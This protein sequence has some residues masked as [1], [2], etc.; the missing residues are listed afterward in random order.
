MLMTWVYSKTQSLLLA[1]LM[2]ASFTGWLL[3]LFPATSLTKNLFWQSAF[4]LTL[5]GMVA[6]ML[7]S[8]AVR[9]NSGRRR[10]P[11][12]AFRQPAEAMQ[13]V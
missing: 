10:A 7:R 4:A 12:E 11:G 8:N 13:D 1:I 2:H 5:W 9:P 6:M 3:A